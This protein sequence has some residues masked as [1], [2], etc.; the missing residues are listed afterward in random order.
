MATTK[1]RSKGL[2]TRSVALLVAALM[3]AACG[4]QS[5]TTAGTLTRT[6][7][8][9]SARPTTST[10]ANPRDCNALGINPVGMREGTCTHGGITYVVVNEDHTLK[11]AT[12]WASLNGV[13]TA[14]SLT[15]DTAVATARGQFLMATLSITNKL[16]H[17]RTFDQGHTQQAGVILDGAVY[18]EDVAAENADSNSCLRQNGTSIQPGDSKTCDVIFDIPTT[19]A[20][21]LGK[22]GSGDL[23]LV[24]FGSDLS[25]STLAQMVGQ[26]RLYH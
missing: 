14:R 15:N 4:G 5:K 13:H 17:P 8:D 7:L 24:N 18:K 2:M 12:L 10:I 1:V 11:L 9:A 23:Y 3:V 25:G 6:T 22:H 26:I 20:A 16:P 21:D 19:A